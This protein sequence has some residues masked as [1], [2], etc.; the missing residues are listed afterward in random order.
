MSIKPLSSSRELPLLGIIR[1]G[2][3]K[4][5]EKKPGRELEYFRVVPRD[6]FEGVAQAFESVFGTEPRSFRARL[7][8]SN[9]DD[10]FPHWLEQWAGG[11]LMRRCDGETILVDRT[12][13]GEDVAGG[14]CGYASGS[15]HCRP[16]GDL[17]LV[18][19]A[20]YEYGYYGFFFLRT[21]SIS[22]IRLIVGLLNDLEDRLKNTVGRL[23]LQDVELDIYRAEE[24]LTYVKGDGSRGSRDHY[25]VKIKLSSDWVADNAALLQPRSGPALPAPAVDMSD[26]L[27]K[28]DQSQAEGEPDLVSDHEP[29][30]PAGMG[31]DHAMIE[32]IKYAAG[33]Y[34]GGMA[35]SEIL[36]IAGVPNLIEKY[37]DDPG[38]AY[39]LIALGIV[40]EQLPVKVYG[41]GVRQDK[42]GRR[43]YAMNFGFGTAYSYTREPFREVGLAVDDRWEV[44]GENIPFEEPLVATI[45]RTA[46]STIYSLG[47]LRKQGPNKPPPTPQPEHLPGQAGEYDLVDLNG[48]NPVGELLDMIGMYLDSEGAMTAV[49][50]VMQHDEAF[51][52]E[53]YQFL[54]LPGPA[55]GLEFIRVAT[56]V[57]MS[58]VI[59]DSTPAAYADVQLGPDGLPLPSESLTMPTLPALD[60][61]PGM[62]KAQ[63]VELGDRVGEELASSWT[64]DKMIERLAPALEAEHQPA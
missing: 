36:N 49:D 59:K 46:N 23:R 14:V 35:P 31:R 5:D 19:P 37:L 47:T 15:C 48:K 29:D 7:A 3:E 39:D 21:N 53:V 62:T 34:L 17:K 50:Y 45:T 32:Y 40:R 64:K 56:E 51:V 58:L 11:L 27:A 22:D 54:D 4:V 16:M 30:R 61:L 63:L 18:I 20:L 8:G 43:R 38:G 13:K 57:V 41:V 24:S 60:E 26:E 28:L 42:S 10:V 9:L 25:L 1:K 6:G 44:D 52:R 2:E 33:R 12:R 55:Q